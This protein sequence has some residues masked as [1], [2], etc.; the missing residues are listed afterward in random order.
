MRYAVAHGRRRSTR[1]AGL[2]TLLR[3]DGHQVVEVAADT[4][5]QARAAC[6]ALVADGLDV[7]VVAGGDGLVS[8]G[9]DLC[10]GTPTALGI[11]PGGTGNDNARSLGIPVGRGADDAAGA[12]AVLRADTRRTVDTL[13]LPEPGRHVLGSVNCALDAR[14]AARADAWPRAL[15]AASYT[16]AA[17]VEVALLGRRPPLRFRLTVDGAP[18]VLDALVLAPANMAYL[19]GGLPLAPRA[20]PTDG[21]L[22]L[23]VI[24]PVGPREALGLLRAV[25]AGRHTGHPAVRIVQAREVRV[26]VHVAGPG[27]VLAHGDGEPVGA[28]PLTV[29]VDPASLQVVAPTLT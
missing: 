15:G 10:A 21:L 17:L 8:M 28:L 5:D 4:L 14:I 11:L 16:L 19:G 26:E 22:D 18:Q 3:A 7:L 24:T 25:R 23:V 12:V 27:G 20:D 29:R 2:I 6:A 13:W 9:T 1:P